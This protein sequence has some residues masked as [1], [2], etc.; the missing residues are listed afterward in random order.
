MCKKAIILFLT[1]IISVYADYANF[2]VC[3]DDGLCSILWSKEDNVCYCFANKLI[4]QVKLHTNDS[5]R[6]YSSDDCIG[7]YVTISNESYV[8]NASWVKS[9][10]SSTDSTISDGCPYS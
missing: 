2:H 3:N 6:L 1:I 7:S 8:Q 9:I 4:T 5:I 10:S